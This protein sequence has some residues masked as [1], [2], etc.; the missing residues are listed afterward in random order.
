MK[1]TYYFDFD[2]A[3]WKMRCQDIKPGDAVLVVYREN[4]LTGNGEY[5]LRPDFAA[6]GMPGN[7]D[8]N[9]KVFHGWRG[10]TNN[11]AAYACGV[12]RVKA[13]NMAEHY[14]SVYGEKLQMLRVTIGR[15][16]IALWKD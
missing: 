12:Y 6:D 9:N 15:R 7:M 10:T 14:S 11:I 2:G 13:V 4:V 5:E 16:D 3:A 1:R 8:S